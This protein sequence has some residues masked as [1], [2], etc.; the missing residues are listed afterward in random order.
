VIVVRVTPANDMRRAFAEWAVEQTPKVRTISS[1]S[2]AVPPHQFTHVPEFLLIGSM[3]DGHQYVPAGP[4]EEEPP[5]PPPSAAAV[6]ERECSG[7]CAGHLPELPAEAYPAG[8]VLLDLVGVDDPAAEDT[9]APEA[10]AEDDVPEP[11][12]E[13]DAVAGTACPDPLCGRTFASPRGL[14]T[15]RRQ[16]HAENED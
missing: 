15:H 6:P 11:E 2:F 16:A 10:A 12:T 5:H 8:A 3:V 1:R 4:E 14:A 13:A 7:R 9:P